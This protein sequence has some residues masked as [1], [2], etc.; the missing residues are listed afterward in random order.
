MA[1]TI[2][3]DGIRATV[4]GWKWKCIEEP[5]IES[6]LNS[7]TPAGGA[8]GEVANP[9]EW[10]ARRACDIFGGTMVSSDPTDSVKGEIH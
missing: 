9:D 10:L 6:A 7:V 8:G 4:D 2:E 3:L 1:A 5:E